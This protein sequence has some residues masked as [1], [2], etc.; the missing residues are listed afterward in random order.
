MIRLSS[1]NCSFVDEARAT[2]WWLRSPVASSSSNFYNV[3]N[4]GN[5]NNNNANNAWGVAFGSSLGCQSNSFVKSVPRWR[6]GELD[7]PEKVNRYP[8]AFSRTLLAWYRLKMMRYF[9]A[10]NATPLLQS[11]DRGTG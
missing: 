6:E 9:M 7:L 10:G 8:D 2:N 3:N 4:N 1:A 11:S 5:S